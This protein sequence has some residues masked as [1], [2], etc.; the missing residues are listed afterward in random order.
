MF[1]VSPN[2]LMHLRTCLPAKGW[3]QNTKLCYSF[4]WIRTISYSSGFG[5]FKGLELNGRTVMQVQSLSIKETVCEHRFI[6][7][8]SPS[9]PDL[10]DCWGKYSG[11]DTCDIWGQPQMLKTFLHSSHMQDTQE[12]YG[13]SFCQ[14]T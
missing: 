11:C 14:Y 5:E 9:G 7:G 1:T 13:V 4:L 10:A 12:N 8:H 6:G 2:P 3:N